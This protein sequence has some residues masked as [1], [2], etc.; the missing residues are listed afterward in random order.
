MTALVL[1]SLAHAADRRTPIVE[2]VE[3]ATPSVVAL[4]VEV[5]TQSPFSV[6]GG[7]TV[8]SSQGSG[9]VIDD[10]GV[11]LTNA[12]V[13]QGATRI[14]AHTI[15]GTSYDA[16][17][18][19][20]DTDLDLAVLKLEEAEGLV[21]IEVADSDDL[22]LG[23][24]A[25]AIGNPYGLGLTVSTGVVA[26]I[27]RQ[28]EI[29]PGIYQAYIQTD[30]A[31]NPGNSGGALVNLEGRL[32]G[33]N[34]AIRAE[35]EGIG[36]AIPANRAKKIADDLL[37]YGSVKAPWLGCDFTDINARR[38]AG[39][40]L[41][42]ALRVAAVHTG[43]PCDAAGMEPGDIVFQID[44]RPTASRADLNA[45]LAQKKPGDKVV[46][47]AVHLDVIV[48]RE[49]ASTDLPKNASARALK[50]LGI[51]VAALDGRGLAITEAAADG[52]WMQA[53]LR[54]G[55]ILVAVDGI[56]VDTPEDLA[57]VL[58]QA[59]AR[60]QPSALFTVRRGRIQGHVPVAI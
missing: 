53:R 28:V 34:T 7:P 60:H 24:T 29:Q 1:L 50:R 25:I 40:G 30:A 44:G 47:E 58:Q 10:D 54:P 2:A 17:P 38:L 46:L 36:F 6:F 49:L 39:T 27:D 31:I 59:K 43:G 20:L 37:L 41:S 21:A 14:R 5:P 19:A 12:H 9:V 22:L 55:D 4:E 8:A 57:K 42:G 18:I 56:R 15:R 33:V 16:R 48:A 3:K 51:A 26:S 52:T 45:W 32:M 11:V 35:A 23:E 13:I